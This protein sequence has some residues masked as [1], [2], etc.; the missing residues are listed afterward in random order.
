MA[1]LATPRALIRAML[2]GDLLP[3]PLLLPIVFSLGARLE[4][5][6]LRAFLGNA[7]KIANSQR[8]IRN[9]LGLDGVTGYFDP[10]LEAEAFGCELKWSADDMKP[11][12]RPLTGDA[13]DLRERLRAPAEIAGRGRIPAACDVLRRLKM[14]LPGEPALMAGVSGPYALAGL[15][16]GNR[17]DAESLRHDAVEFVAELTAA[18][19][20]SFLESGGNVIFIREDNASIQD[21]KQWAELLSPIVNAIRFYEALPV[22]LL[23]N[24]P[25]EAAIAALEAGCEGVICPRAIDLAS[26]RNLS[27]GTAL[28]AAYLPDACFLP[29]QKEGSALG[30]SLQVLARDTS[31]SVLTSQGDV[32]AEVDVK[33][34]A[35]LFGNLSGVSRV[36]A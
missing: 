33:H 20:T 15:L 2:R 8:Q 7:T 23:G 11:V 6:S 12:L 36:V 3:R 19:C 13:S 25:P 27:T 18:V 26:G 10:Y 9:G 16:V 35:S 5:L 29:A 14:M 28:P 32:P 4:N 30:K 17:E 31:L 24:S 22:L 21:Y 34:L 1:E